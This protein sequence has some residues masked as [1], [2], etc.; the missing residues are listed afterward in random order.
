MAQTFHLSKT[1]LSLPLAGACLLAHAAWPERPVTMVVGFTAG[2]SAD[3]LARTIAE[4]LAR[5]LGVPVIVDN[6]AGAGGSIAAQKVVRAR[7]DGYTIFL[8]SSSE[9]ILSRHFNNAIAY[10]GARDL[11]AVTLVGVMPMVLVA[12]PR[13]PATTVDAMLARARSHPGQENYASSGTGTALHIAGALIN[14]QA[15]VSLQHVPYKGAVPMLTDIVGGNVDYGFFMVPSILGY[16]KEGKVKPIGTTSRT[17]CAVL[18]GVPAL[19]SAKAL[20]GYDF[21]IWTGIFAP[22]AVPDA[23]VARLNQ[24][25]NAVLHES[26]VADKLDQAC[27]EHAGGTPAEFERLIQADVQKVRQVARPEIGAVR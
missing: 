27:I 9:V 3:I 5:R 15:H 10:D 17:S 1:L 25:I 23:V 26:P 6:V 16:L 14:Q 19:S 11:R 13:T 7:P 12:G 4:P 21:G 22:K 24:E 8:G 20:A 2:G 18:A